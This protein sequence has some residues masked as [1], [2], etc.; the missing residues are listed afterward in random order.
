[1]KSLIKVL[2]QS[3]TTRI[4]QLLQPSRREYSQK[5]TP[6]EKMV[7]VP[8]DPLWDICSPKSE[9]ARF[10]RPDI[11]DPSAPIRW[12]EYFKYVPESE[13]HRYSNRGKFYRDY[14][15]KAFKNESE[16]EGCLYPAPS[17][18]YRR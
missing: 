6:I 2:Q 14:P 4:S 3:S 9:Y 11:K 10:H 12:P 13:A 15:P 8:L 18:P 7:V 16:H 5:R 1:M 17:P